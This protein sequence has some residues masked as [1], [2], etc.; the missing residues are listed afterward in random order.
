MVSHVVSHSKVS[1][2]SI[3][4]DSTPYNNTHIK[5]IKNVLFQRSLQ[6][7]LM[8]FCYENS[9]HKLQ[10]L[11]ESCKNFLSKFYEIWPIDIPLIDVFTKSPMCFN[12]GFIFSFLLITPRQALPSLSHAVKGYTSHSC[13]KVFINSITLPPCVTFYFF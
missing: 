3:F 2:H 5:S 11:K 7:L 12:Q 10:Y 9:F 6:L 13:F 1:F 8:T 4:S